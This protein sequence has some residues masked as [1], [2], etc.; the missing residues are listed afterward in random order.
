MHIGSYVKMAAFVDKYLADLKE[1]PISILDVGSLD[2]NGTYRQLFNS[3]NWN[4]TGCDIAAGKNVDAVLSNI[5]SWS[6]FESNQFDVVISGQ[7]F[8]HVE[9][10]WFTI[11]EI[12]RVLKESGYCCIIAPSA[13]G[14]HRYPVDCWRFYPDGLRALAKYAGLEVKEAYTEWQDP[15]YPDHCGFWKDSV[16]VCRKP[17]MS[18]KQRSLFLKKIQLSKSIIDLDRLSEVE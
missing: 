4:Y 5:Y 3:V 18:D 2:V 15:G 13:G 8:E 16:L 7:V 10:F 14:E 9:F 17:V 11:L 12:A 1:E 6:E